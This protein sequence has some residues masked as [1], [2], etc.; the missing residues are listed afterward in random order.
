MLNRRFENILGGSSSE[1]TCL[2]G[3]LICIELAYI[4][5]ILELIER[6][7]YAS[8]MWCNFREGSILIKDAPWFLRCIEVLFWEGF[9][10]LD[11]PP[12]DACDHCWRRRLEYGS[13]FHNF[14][15]SEDLDYSAL[16][17]C[18]IYV[19]FL[20]YLMVLLSATT[21]LRK[22]ALCPKQNKFYIS[23]GKMIS[24]MLLIMS[25]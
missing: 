20:V 14:M 5:Y 6:L 24:E 21:W 13:V 1:M 8:E 16:I 4:A 12:I 2:K 17:K 18:V 25:F 15:H 10:D 9:Y 23:N 11:S 22:R 7:F 3:T 19:A